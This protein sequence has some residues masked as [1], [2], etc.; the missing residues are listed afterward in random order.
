MPAGEPLHHLQ[1]HG[2]VQLHFLASRTRQDAD[3]PNGMTVLAPAA[4]IEKRLIEPVLRR[5]IEIAWLDAYHALVEYELGPS[6]SG[7]ERAWLAEA[8]RPL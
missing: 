2:E 7:A 6:L 8:C 1:L 4:T 3:G 5:L